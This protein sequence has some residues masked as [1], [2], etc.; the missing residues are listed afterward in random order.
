ML[1]NE[2]FIR[3]SQDKENEMLG[4]YN[5]AIFEERY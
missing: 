1:G 3:L 5:F 4:C 2:F